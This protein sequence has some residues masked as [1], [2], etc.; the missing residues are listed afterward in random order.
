MEKLY[1]AIAVTDV[2]T[3]KCYIRHKQC[4]GGSDVIT[5][6]SVYF[7]AE[8]TDAYTYGDCGKDIPLRQ[9]R[10]PNR[11][12]GAFGGIFDED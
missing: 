8:R 10:N 4:V 5:S 2:Q 11:E 3:G 12:R 1:N 7:P 9:P 6:T